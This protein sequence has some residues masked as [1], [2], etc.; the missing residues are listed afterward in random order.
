MEVD[1]NG[2]EA[3]M[4]TKIWMFNLDAEISNFFDFYGF[5]CM[6]NVSSCAVG[7]FNITF[8]WL[9]VSLADIYQI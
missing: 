5:E 6:K 8:T 3:T 4:S 1:L 2:D 7:L 9:E